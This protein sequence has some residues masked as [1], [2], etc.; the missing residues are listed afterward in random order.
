MLDF[1]K[2]ARRTSAEREANVKGT[3]LFESYAQY[4]AIGD[5]P[6]IP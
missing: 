3:K 4:I 5:Q 2:L 1:A 6:R